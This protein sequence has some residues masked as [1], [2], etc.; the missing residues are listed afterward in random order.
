MKNKEPRSDTKKESP[1]NNS[2]WQR[3]EPDSP[4]QNICLIHPEAKICIGCY[5]ST[6]EISGWKNMTKDARLK[7]CAELSQRASLLTKRHRKRKY[8]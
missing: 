7:L 2:V 5:R 8:P 6:D 1:R 3:D 4:C